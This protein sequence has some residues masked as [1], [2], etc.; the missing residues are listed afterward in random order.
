MSS[1][2]S[3]KKIHPFLLMA[4]LCGVAGV[5]LGGTT[6]WAESNRCWQAATP[7]LECLTKSP[8]VKT[9]EGMGAGLL[10]GIGAAMGVAW[11]IKRE[12]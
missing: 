12:P 3:Y 4:F 8:T 2:K 5:V 10:A 9:L 6:S 1:P 11:Q 7:K